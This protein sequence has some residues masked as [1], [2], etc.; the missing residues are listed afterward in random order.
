MQ[1][2]GKLY[3][4]RVPC[5]WNHEASYILYGICPRLAALDIIGFSVILSTDWVKEEVSIVKRSLKLIA[6]AGLSLVLAV[7]VLAPLTTY[8]A[9]V[10]SDNTAN[11]QA[12]QSNGKSQAYYRFEEVLSLL[13]SLHISGA[14]KD[15]LLDA[16]LQG[17]IDSLDD[18]YTVYYEPAKA[19]AFHNAVNG[20]AVGLGFRIATN[21]K[22]IYVNQ[23][24]PRS[25][26]E[27]S[28]LQAGDYLLALGEQQDHVLTMI[29]LTKALLGK[30]EGDTIALTIL[31]GDE[32]KVISLT[33]KSIQF[34]ITAHHLLEGKVGYIALYSFAWN[35]E[36]E[37]AKAM[38]DL[39]SQGM[40]SLIIDLRD[41][42]GGYVDAAQKLAG[43]F[44]EAGTFMYEKKQGVLEPHALEIKEG[45]HVD[46]PITVLINNNSASA[47]EMFAGFMQ[48]HK[49]ATIIGAR[50]YGKG[51]AQHVIPLISGGSLK[52]TD[53]EWL[54]PEKHKVNDEGIGPDIEVSGEIEPLIRGILALRAPQVDLELTDTLTQVNQIE[55]PVNIPF[56]KIEESY[57][58]PA[59]LLAALAEAD[60]RW[61]ATKR[62][63]TIKSKMIDISYPMSSVATGDAFLMNGM[64]WI[65]LDVFQKQLAGLT[66]AADERG[67]E[68]HF[69]KEEE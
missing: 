64:S 33:F 58:V 63:V 48:D 19:G 24:F 46:L 37:F 44:I 25:P 45:H 34:P 2:S 53:M 29:A 28:G 54:T 21:D 23:V 6:S 12:D 4:A 35:A 27:Q 16:A 5:R 20:Q 57:Y 15:D 38:A 43:H 7:L 52:V 51:V 60:V 39:Q 22:G 42:G 68:L 49:L 65:R 59:R 13:S 26:A 31:H 18:P 1:Q 41:N 32:K 17:M 14:T 30:K 3:I 55:W 66:W 40:T 69:K 56:K 61:D 8:A 62:E 9:N 47:S 11:S 36:L 67:L 10:E 50:S